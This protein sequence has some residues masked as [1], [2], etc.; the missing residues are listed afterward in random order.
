MDER[1]TDWKTYAK[2]MRGKTP[3]DRE[4]LERV[5]RGE[6]ELPEIP[7][8]TNRGPRVAM[9]G[10]AVSGGSLAAQIGASRHLGLAVWPLLAVLCM[11]MVAIG[12]MWERYQ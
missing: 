5:V 1:P 8:P 2:R 6:E 12:I 4:W 3:E 9:L 10:L 7:P 11:T